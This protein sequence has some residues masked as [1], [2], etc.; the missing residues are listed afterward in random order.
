M[1]YFHLIASRSIF[2]FEPPRL[3]KIDTD[4]K[5]QEE[6]SFDKLCEAIVAFF[7]FSIL[8]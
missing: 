7:C 4:K 3:C 1:S 5:E 8:T 2:L 6:A